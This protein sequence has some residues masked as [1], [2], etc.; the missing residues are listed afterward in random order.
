MTLLSLSLNA[1]EI[2]TIHI[3]TDNRPDIV[4]FHARSTLVGEQASYIV[5]WKTV[6][7]T[8]VNITFI[9]KVALSGSLTITEGEYN[10]GEIVLKASNHNNSHVDIAVINKHRA[11]DKATPIHHRRSRY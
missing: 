5:T 7:A 3:P 8:D 11:G 9:G 2:P 4:I 6:N 1:Y 10:R